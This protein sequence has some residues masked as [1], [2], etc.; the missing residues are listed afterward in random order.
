MNRRPGDPEL[1]VTALPEQPAAEQPSVAQTFG[2]WLRSLAGKG[3]ETDET[4]AERLGEDS[5]AFDNL[6]PGEKLIL[7]NVLKLGE[8]R[9]GD[10]MVP[11]ADI[12]GVTEDVRLAEL[13][14]SFRDGVHSR[15]PVYRANLDDVVGFV[16]IKDVLEFWDR[17]KPFNLRRIVR[18]I[19]FVP[20]SMLV[21]DLLLKM[22]LTRVHVAIV[23][24]EYGGTHGLVSIEDLVEEI[25]GEIEGEHARVRGPIFTV[26]G[27][28]SIVAQGRAPVM[29]IEE[30]LGVAL[31]PE[32]REEEIETLGGLLVSLAGRVPMRGELIAHPAGLEF[33]VLD[34]DPRR[35]KRVRIAG[36]KN[37]TEANRTAEEPPAPEGAPGA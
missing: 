2:D 34:S 16:H 7:L 37:V 15:L 29:E 22:R 35:V 3:D 11:R 10:V 30:R 21:V 26:K 12:V 9:V 8:V 32:E 1:D 20:A 13:I 36:V 17:A 28:G 4:L 27:D 6:T 5:R 25:V 24:D 31:V 33:E 23:V 19:L 14:K 18:E